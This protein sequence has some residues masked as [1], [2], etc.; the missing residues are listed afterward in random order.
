MNI[1]ID[2]L[3]YGHRKDLID[4]ANTEYAKEKLKLKKYINKK[5]V[6]R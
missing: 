6:L 5:G 4:R 2:D 3:A 1:A